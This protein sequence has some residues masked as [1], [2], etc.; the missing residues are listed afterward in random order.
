MPDNS[1]SQTAYVTAAYRAAAHKAYPGQKGGADHMAAYFLPSHISALLRFRKIRLMGR[2][3]DARLHPGLFEYVVARSIF[4]DTVF[5]D[6]LKNEVPQIVFLGAGYD[7]RAYR[8]AERNRGT[9]IFELDRPDIQERKR[10]VLQPHIKKD[11]RV[12]YVPADFNKTRLRDVLS[13]ETA[14]R[15]D[16]KTLFLWEGV[17]MYLE[18]SSVEAV[19]NYV[20]SEACEG[21]RIV[22]D[23]ALKITEEN[24]GNYYGAATIARLLKKDGFREPFLFTLGEDE[25]APFLKARGLALAA[26]MDAAQ[27][28]QLFRSGTTD[29]ESGAKPTG[30]FCFAIA[31]PEAA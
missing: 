7:T 1:V 19:L 2:K 12:F 15:P 29:I 30:M 18:P 10:Q 6:A 3:R 28:E 20:A 23:Y 11:D 22:F 21:S 8:F 26:H 24:A 17:C 31:T 5:V 9:R 14:Y 16:Q 25:I 27:I 4:F 13:A